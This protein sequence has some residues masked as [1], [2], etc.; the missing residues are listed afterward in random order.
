MK[1]LVYNDV[2][3]EVFKTWVDEW[4]EAGVVG[5]ALQEFRE[6]VWKT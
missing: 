2:D 4:L 1:R 3:L 6:D 5:D